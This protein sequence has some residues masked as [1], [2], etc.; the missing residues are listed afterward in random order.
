[1]GNFRDEIFLQALHLSG[2]GARL[3]IIAT[4]VKQAVRDVEKELVLEG[5]SE[6][7]RLPSGVS[8]LIT[9]SPC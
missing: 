7:A 2:A 5:G 4:Q 1:V 9:I 3:V 8:A 6:G